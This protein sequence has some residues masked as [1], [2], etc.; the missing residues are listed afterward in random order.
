MKY[1]TAIKSAGSQ[2]S[3]FLVRVTAP[4][5]MADSNELDVSEGRGLFVNLQTRGGY[6]LAKMKIQVVGVFVN[7]RYEAVTNRGFVLKGRK[8]MVDNDLKY[9]YCYYPFNKQKHIKVLNDIYR[10]GDLLIIFD[11]QYNMSFEKKNK[12]FALNLYRYRPGMLKNYYV[13]KHGFLKNDTI[14][15]V[16]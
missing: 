12:M 15:G 16:R 14:Q 7:N 2:N 1:S 9:E 6:R 11:P 8:Y 10:S 3:L 13:L 5:E 4:L